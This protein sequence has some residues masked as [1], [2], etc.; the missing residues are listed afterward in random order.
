LYVVSLA[1]ASVGFAMA[2]SAL[3]QVIVLRGAELG[4]KGVKQSDSESIAV[5]EL[6]T[7]EGCS[8]C[9]PADK[10]LRRIATSADAIDQKVFP[11]SFHVDYWNRLGWKDPFSQAA[12]S[13]RQRDYATSLK[14]DSVY[15]PQ[16]IVNGT[17]EFVGSDQK[18]TDLA[19]H[20][21]LDH[22]AKHLV[23]LSK[24]V[25][26][27]QGHLSFRYQVAGS[28]AKA[29]KNS[30]YVL[31]V[32]LAT[33]METVSVRRGENGGREL[34]HAWVVKSLQVLPLDSSA[35]TFEISPELVKE[36]HTRIVAYVQ[37]RTTREISG[38]SA[39][40]L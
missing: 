23:S 38:A 9:P 30:D 1:I 19:I 17:T 14:A 8:S 4:S 18:L 37:S 31:N 6:F 10:N 21:A 3:P 24:I 7:S 5:V 11:L 29:E 2:F 27:D 22:P 35:G 20:E 40:S 26:K 28:V 34:S 36:K 15:T 32:A 39:L 25:E 12:Y 13:E 16:M 33:D